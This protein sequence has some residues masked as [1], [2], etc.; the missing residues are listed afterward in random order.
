MTFINLAFL[1]NH[2][3]QSTLCAAGAWL[4]TF[5]L[6]RNRAAVRYWL[7]LAASLKFLVP[8]AALVAIGSRF[9]WRTPEL[10]S[11]PAA[12][13][14]WTTMIT[15]VGRP[16]AASVP[17]THAPA[18]TV[19]HPALSLSAILFVIWL[20]GF[21]VVVSLWIRNWMR[22]GAIERRGTLLNL[23]LPIPVVSSS[24]PIEPGVFGILRPVLLLPEGIQARLTA[25]Q[26]EAIVAHEMCHVRRRDNLL[27]AIHMV[28][29][30]IFWF[31][32][33][34]WWIGTRMVDER[35]RACD[36]EVL[37]SGRDPEPYAQG[38]LN[39][40]KFYTES[41][42]ACASG[43]SGSDL[44]S[45]IVR[46]MKQGA[47]DRL[48]FS[49]KVLLGSAAVI[50]LAGPLI[51]GA[52]RAAQSFVPRTS[53]DSTIA[54]AVFEVASIKVN[55]SGERGHGSHLTGDLF[56]A[57]NNS[58][59]MLIEGAY[60]IN[61]DQLLGGPK[62]ID[63][64][65]FDIDAKIDS[66]VADRFGALSPQQRGLALGHML[67]ALLADRFKLTLQQGS[68]R[69]PVFVLVVAK[70]GPRLHES[71]P[72]DTYATGY[73]DRNGNPTGAG[74]DSDAAGRLSAQGV[75]IAQFVR[76]LSRQM[77]RTVL[78]KT[79]LAGKY[80][81]TLQ[82]SP[83]DRAPMRFFADRGQTVDAPALDSLGPSIF[84]AIQEQ[85]GLKLEPS[86]GPVQIL[87]I[88]SI[89]RPTEN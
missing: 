5:V 81:F 78:D 46:I 41:S 55:K 43:I 67:Q 85:L 28:V 51:F 59:R 31:Y 77:D 3:W 54:S 10:A 13:L 79:G 6:R 52:T 21:V 69:L 17:L 63:S 53:E 75:S 15:D 60:G 88:K 42:L 48:S 65:R 86:K 40:C 23:A 80:D 71:M 30:A 56:V 58:V 7:W 1:E 72:G 24:T 27:E 57:R 47:A 73:K 83:D 12:S 38:I 22:A 9:G 84:T 16:F 36:E 64:E 32:P 35:E 19:T 70:N 29:E 20:G 18:A 26:F 89:E 45:R 68:K 4:L 74:F 62:W 39:V 33:P 50:A 37:Q 49:R 25:N 87:V 76:W 82:W 8:F 11:D 14:Q 66:S 44:K 2:L 34:L 61:N